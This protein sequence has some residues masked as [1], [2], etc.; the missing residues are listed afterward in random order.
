M[1]D[2]VTF[3]LAGLIVAPSDVL[4]PS[5]PSSATSSVRVRND[6]RGIAPRSDESDSATSCQL[7]QSA[8]KHVDLPR[9]LREKYSGLAR[10]IASADNDDLFAIAELRLHRRRG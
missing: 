10:G 1:T 5:V 4:E 8:D 2:V 7:V 6:D 3:D 9:R